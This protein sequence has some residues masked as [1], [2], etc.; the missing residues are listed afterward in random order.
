MAEYCIDCFNKINRLNLSKKDVLCDVD[1]CE[2]CGEIKECVIVIKRPSLIK[3]WYKFIKKQI[4]R[5]KQ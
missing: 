2:G 1:L 4:N 5:N 3:A